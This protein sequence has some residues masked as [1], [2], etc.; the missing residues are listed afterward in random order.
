MKAGWAHPE[1]AS[2]C[3]AVCRWGPSPLNDSVAA[4]HVAVR[5]R[6]ET[7]CS[8]PQT[9]AAWCPLAHM[10]E[11]D[12]ASPA[13]QAR[14]QRCKCALLQVVEAVQADL[15][16]KVDAGELRRLLEGKAGVEDVNAALLEV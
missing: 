9:C 3:S 4:A 7:C 16:D 1:A 2:G 12:K 15:A 14:S 6:S 5:Q 13:L 8:V 11:A 10:W